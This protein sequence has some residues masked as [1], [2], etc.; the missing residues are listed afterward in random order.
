MQDF[1]QS[2]DQ[3]A[4]EQQALAR[5]ADSAARAAGISLP[6][7]TSPSSCPSLSQL[8][9]DSNNQSMP[10]VAGVL[11]PKDCRPHR[12]RGSVLLRSIDDNMVMECTNFWPTNQSTAQGDPLPAVQPNKSPREPESS[13]DRTNTILPLKA[14]SRES[15]IQN[16]M[17]E[18]IHKPSQHENYIPGL[19]LLDKVGGFKFSKD[20]EPIYADK[21]VRDM[22]DNLRGSRGSMEGASDKSALKMC[23]ANVPKVA[24]ISRGKLHY[25]QETTSSK[26]KASRIRKTTVPGSQKK[27]GSRR[28]TRGSKDGKSSKPLTSVEEATPAVSELE[29]VPEEKQEP[30]EEDPTVSSGQDGPTSTSTHKKGAGAQSKEKVLT[31]MRARMQGSTSLQRKFGDI[32]MISQQFQVTDP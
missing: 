8:D 7:L 32:A 17:L 5:L 6:P 1:I 3:I 2:I 9:S 27:R 30:T 29:V 16:I 23:D 18:P 14:S 10:F 12:T 21:M 4:T 13:N 19:K 11:S 26:K 25:L 20:P 22:E 31:R 28:S 15:S 24:V